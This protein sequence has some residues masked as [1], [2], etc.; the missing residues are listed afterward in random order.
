M[1]LGLLVIGDDSLLLWFCLRRLRITKKFSFFYRVRKMEQSENLSLIQ[2]NVT[3]FVS[4]GKVELDMCHKIKLYQTWWSANE[5]EMSRSVKQ[6]TC[7]VMKCQIWMW[8]VI[9][10]KIR[11]L[12]KGKQRKMLKV[13]NSIEFS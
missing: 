5:H 13:I 9:K 3:D 12:L 7:K 8:K 10:W 2:F 4:S 6:E 1:M 11:N